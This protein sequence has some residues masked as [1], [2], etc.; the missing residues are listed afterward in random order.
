ML[1]DSGTVGGSEV[2]MPV[3]WAVSVMGV[4]EVPILNGYLYINRY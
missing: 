4:G 3:A 2:R 1:P